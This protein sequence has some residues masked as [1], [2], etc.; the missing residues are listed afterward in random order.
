MKKKIIVGFSG[1]VDS[2]VTV[3]LLKRQG[4]QVTGIFLDMLGQSEESKRAKILAKQLDIEF[5]QE[6][7]KKVFQKKIINQFINSYKNGLT[8]NPCIACNPKIK[9]RYLLQAADKL[10][11][12]DIATG[13]YAIVTNNSAGRKVLL[14][15]KDKVKDQ[16][17]FLYRLTQKELQRSNFPLGHMLKKDIK[18]IAKENDLKVPKLESQDVCFLKNFKNLEEFLQKQLDKKDFNKGIIIDSDGNTVGEHQGLLIYTLGQRKGLNIGGDGP[19]YVIGKDFKKNELLVSNVKQDKKLLNKEIVIDN[20][21][22]I[23]EEPNKDDVYQIKIR[24]QMQA[25][26]AKIEKYDNKQ[27]KVKCS[28]PIWAITPGQALVVYVG[29]KVVGGGTIV[30]SREHNVV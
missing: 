27:W 2:A 30:A 8:P 28:E 9:F 19:F 4:Y 18:A 10:G 26:Q 5:I 3:H 16:S 6:D 29:D 25:V 20:V 17:Y 13:H 23:N 15:G 22:W 12:K 1:G 24:Y 21:S 11:I 7:I 14:K